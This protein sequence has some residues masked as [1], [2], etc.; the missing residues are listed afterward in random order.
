MDSDFFSFLLCRIFIHRSTTLCWLPST[1]FKSI[2]SFQFFL[3]Q[4]GARD[5]P[6]KTKRYSVSD[7]ED[8]LH[9]VRS[10]SQLNDCSRLYESPQCSGKQLKRER[11]V[12]SCRHCTERNMIADARV[13][14]SVL[15]CI[16]C[17]R[18]SNAKTY[19]PGPSATT[20][21]LSAFLQIFKMQMH[22]IRNSHSVGR[23]CYT[24][25]R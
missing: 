25:A 10:L 12:G 20:N 19:W 24:T 18:S 23:K 5:V 13:A 14:E 17:M 6:V 16:V 3:C 4:N 2:I 22:I 1:S 8:D 9:V 11:N 15:E 7:T 21:P